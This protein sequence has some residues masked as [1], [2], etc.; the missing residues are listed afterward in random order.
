MTAPH[1]RTA[2]RQGHSRQESSELPLRTIGLFN[3]LTPD[4]LAAVSGRAITRTYAANEHILYE[5]EPCQA[6]YF[7]LHGHVR[8]Y[9]LSPE[10]R[11]QVLVR[12]GAGQAFNTVPPFQ[13]GGLN[14]ASVV[15]TEPTELLRLAK[16][17]F[18][19][20]T[21]SHRD[22]AAAM[23]RDFADRLVHLAGLVEDLALYTVR[24]RLIRFLLDQADR[25]IESRSH[26]GTGEA[27]ADADAGEVP[28]RWTQQDIA[29][30][31]GTVRDVVGRALRALE[32]E[33]L[34]RI[35]HGR[36]LLLNR[37]ELE[38]RAEA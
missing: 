30:H 25:A 29:A 16:E 20:L 32:D 18:L 37:R 36:I 22:L 24:Q 34:V 8:V 17:D 31:L 13:E 11:E 4:T 38:Q 23:F 2:D 15:T 33:E 3:T 6:V 1:H 21:L 19:Q 35:D 7:V 26:A 28:Q 27:S 10:G 14:Q 9:R 5:G 12:L